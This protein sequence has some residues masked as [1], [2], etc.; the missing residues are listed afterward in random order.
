MLKAP[1]TRHYA[2]GTMTRHYTQGTL[3]EA[4][5]AQG[6]MDKTPCTRYSK[7]RVLL[8]RHQVH[9][10]MNNQQATFTVQGTT[11]RAHAQEPKY[12]YGILHKTLCR[13]HNIQDKHKVPCTIYHA[14]GNVHT[15]PHSEGTMH[16]RSYPWDN[17][18]IK[19]IIH[20]ALCACYPKYK[21]SNTR[22]LV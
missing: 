12:M 11:H 20:P 1:F 14:Q 21:A 19:P 4:H 5:H 15:V 9:C 7:H 6:T 10:A 8:I 17:I 22:Y 3:H 2:Q 13:G 18:C 16:K